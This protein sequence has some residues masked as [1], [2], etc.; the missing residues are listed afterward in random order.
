MDL[1]ERSPALSWID[2]L[3]VDAAAGTGALACVSGPA[4]IGKTALLN[5]SREMA[6][7][8]GFAIAAAL[9][10]ELEA[11]FPFGIVRQLYGRFTDGMEPHEHAAIA[12]L[13]GRLDEPGVLDVSF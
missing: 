12:P 3:L 10:S 13:F 5:A 1:I 9:G 8:R 6:A 2:E 4:G 7:A 11:G